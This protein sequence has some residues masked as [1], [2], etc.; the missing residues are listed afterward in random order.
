M[1]L[2]PSHGKK[3]IEINLSLQ[4]EISMEK[5]LAAPYVG[6]KHR[7]K[8]DVWVKR[9]KNKATTS[10]LDILISTPSFSKMQKI[11][12]VSNCI[13]T[14]TIITKRIQNYFEDCL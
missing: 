12:N 2:T 1:G 7:Y 5:I 14:V 10:C 3:V 6:Q 11:C 8:C 4:E 13:L 9:T